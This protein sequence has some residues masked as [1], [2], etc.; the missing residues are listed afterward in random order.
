[1]LQV[2]PSS[3]GHIEF[4][5]RNFS[6]LTSDSKRADVFTLEN[7]SPQYYSVCL[8]FLETKNQSFIY[9][10][11][12][13]VNGLNKYGAHPLCLGGLGRSLFEKT[14]ARSPCYLFFCDFFI[15]TDFFKSCFSGLLCLKQRSFLVGFLVHEQSNVLHYLHQ[16]LL[17]H[18]FS[19]KLPRLP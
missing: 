14:L 5:K 11:R 10:V 18:I 8:R 16:D 15:G 3:G 17:V 6:N 13:V 2:K 7:V 4:L 9:N 1:M 12:L 19:S